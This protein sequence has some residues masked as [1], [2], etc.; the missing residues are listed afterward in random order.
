MRI[1]GVA[2]APIVPAPTPLLSPYS[3]CSYSTVNWRAS[4]TLSGVYKFEQ[5]WYTYINTIADF[6]SHRKCIA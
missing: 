1:V 6:L 4:E 5:V 3:S 2:H